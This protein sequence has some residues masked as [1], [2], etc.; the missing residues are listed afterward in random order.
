MPS[1]ALSLQGGPDEPTCLGTTSSGGSRETDVVPRARGAPLRG[2]Q[3]RLLHGNDDRPVVPDGAALD[4]P[5]PES[6]RLHRDEGDPER[7]EEMASPTAD[8]GVAADAVAE[9]TCDQRPDDVADDKCDGCLA[10]TPFHEVTA[11]RRAFGAAA[12]CPHAASM[13]RPRV[14]RTV[15]GTRAR[16]SD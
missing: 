4:A 6:Q 7:R 11:A 1:T 3:R 9:R 15:T 14:S 5:P 8:N 10:P 12:S 13:S 16:S 2:G